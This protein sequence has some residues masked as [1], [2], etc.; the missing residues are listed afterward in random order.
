MTAIQRIFALLILGSGLHA[1]ETQHGLRV[2]SGFTVTEF[3]GSDLANDIYTM[4]IDPKGRILVAGRGYIRFLLDENNDGKADR[5]IQ[6]SNTP[7]DGAMGLLWE[8]DSLYCTG[9]GGLRRFRDRN[10]DLKADGPSEIIRRLKTGGEHSAH[11]IRRGPDGWLYVLC[12]NFTGVDEKYA[13]TPGSP[14]KKPIGGTVIR[15]S[16]DLKKSEIVADGFRNS[17]GMDFNSKGDLFNYDSDNERCVTL[18]WYEHTRFYHV[19]PGGHHGWRSPQMAKWWRFPPHF[20]DV[21][22]PLVTCERGS[23]TGVACYRHRQFPEKYRDGFFLC[24]WTFGIVYFVQLTPSGASY[25]AKR[26]TFLKAIGD[27]GFA[28]TGVAVHPQTGDLFVSIGGRGTRGAVYRIRYDKGLKEAKKKPGLTPLAKSLTMKDDLRELATGK[29]ARQRLRAIQTLTENRHRV[30]KETLWTV[31]ENNLD[32]PDRFIRQ[33][34]SRLISMLGKPPMSVWKVTSDSPRARLTLGFGLVAS[35]PALG[36]QLSGFYK[37]GEDIET[38]LAGTRLLQIALG[39]L[40]D[41]KVQGTVHEGYTARKSTDDFRQLVGALISS[42]FPSGNRLLDMELSRTLAMVQYKRPDAIKPVLDKLTAASRPVDDI[43]YLTVLSQLQGK[44]SPAQTKQTADAMLALDKKI[45]ARNLNRDRHWPLR[46]V[47]LHR[48]LAKR[49]ANLNQELLK[50]P[51][52]G[53][54]SHV[55]WTEIRGIDKKK[56]AERFLAKV[57]DDYEWNAQVLRLLGRLPS[58]KVFPLLRKLWNQVGLDNVILSI[59]ARQ[60]EKADREKFLK[61]LESAVAFN[62]LKKLPIQK[63]STT[64]LAVIQAMRNLPTGKAE[65]QHRKR[66]GAYLEELTGVNHGDNREAWAVWFRKTY[67]KQAADLTSPGGV[68]WSKWKERLAKVD[69]SLGNAERGLSIYKRTSCISCHSGARALGPD[70]KGVTG[71]FSR[72]DLFAAIVQPDKDVSSRYRT[73]SVETEQGKFYKGVVVYEAVDSVILQTGAAKTIRLDNMQIVEKTVLARSLMPP[74]LL[75]RLKD[76]ELADLY[77]YLRS[78]K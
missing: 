5:A 11:A 59:L 78:L 43:H 65:D 51:D 60:P 28:P 32:H 6:F 68:D 50:H 75:D 7:K 30:K 49:D 74:G 70:L 71:R 31:V 77:A 44:R 13:Q 62:A 1:A 29:D 41:S 36:V 26:E 42:S 55:V 25:Q 4:T 14:I 54:P 73:V 3:A 21:V 16:P 20:A 52:F 57:T 53:R 15:F 46:I 47:E 27:N 40:V 35:R 24:D 76:E 22:P 69:W 72:E 19:I 2:P 56:A 37:K 9:D 39:G 17:Y 18:P 61:S 67:P 58:E 33:A 38:R 23:P 64:I 10:G 34:I 63:D 48:S 8:G 12:G 45:E 66:L